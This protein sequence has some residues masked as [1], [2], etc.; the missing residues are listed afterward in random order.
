MFSKYGNYTFQVTIT[1][2]G[3]MTA[4]SSVSV[5]VNQ[6]LTTIVVSPSSVSL[7][8]GAMQQFTATARD[9]FVA[10]MATQPTFNWKRRWE[11]SRRQVV[12]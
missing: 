9:Q 4:T 7:N 5:D 3:G 11:R 10:T 1:D 2:P 6:S 12:Y 8:A